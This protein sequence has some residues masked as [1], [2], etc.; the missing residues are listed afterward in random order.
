MRQAGLAVA[1]QYAAVTI[2]IVATHVAILFRTYLRQNVEAD[3]VAV[4]DWQTGH[5]KGVSIEW[6]CRCMS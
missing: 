1:F 2:Q 4:W 5:C 3:S 6:H